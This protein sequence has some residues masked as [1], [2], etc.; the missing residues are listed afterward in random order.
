MEKCLGCE[1]EFKNWRSLNS[2]KRFCEEWQALG[3][4][5]RAQRGPGTTVEKRKQIPAKCPLCDKEFRNVYSMSAHKGHCSGASSTKQFDKTRSLKKDK[6]LKPIEEVFVIHEKKKTA[7]VKRAL[8]KL[9]IKEENKCESCGLDEWMGKKM[10]IE[11]DHINGNNLDNRLENLRFLCPNCHSQTPTWRG[12][13][14]GKD[15]KLLD[16]KENLK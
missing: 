15:K 9:G 3:M 12:R 11:L 8:I 2:H 1:K 10:I 4:S 6:V 5:I 16:K 14:I 7:Y 13:N